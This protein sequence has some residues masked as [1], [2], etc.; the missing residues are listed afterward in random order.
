MSMIEELRF[1]YIGGPSILIE[2]GGVRL[3]T[4]PTFDPAG[5]VYSSGPVTLVKTAG[6][7]VEPSSFGAI[8]GLMPGRGRP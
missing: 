2:I 3:L 5:K 8:R 4:D 7:A 6:P 1:T